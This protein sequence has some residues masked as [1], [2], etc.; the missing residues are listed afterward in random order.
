MDRQ[1]KRAH[2]ARRTP[3]PRRL[4]PEQIEAASVSRRTFLK[5]SGA[6]AAV[7]SVAVVTG[8]C[9]S[10]T[11]DD[12]PFQS[13]ITEPRPGAISDPTPPPPEIVPGGMLRFFSPDE[14]KLVDALASRIMPGSADDPGAHEAGVIWYIDGALAQ[15]VFNQPIYHEPPF[16]Q[17]YD[18]PT[19]PD[20]GDFNTVYVSKDELKRY[21]YQSALTPREMYRVGLA[22]LNSYAQKKFNGKFADISDD[23]K[24]SII[25]EMAGTEGNGAKKKPESASSGKAPIDEVFQAPSA[26]DFFKLVRD[27][28]IY[29][30]FADPAYGGN[31][32]MAG[33]KMIGYPG[34]QRAYTPR[35]MAT[36]GIGLQR[37]PQTL[38][39]LEVFH[40]GVDVGSG[41]ILPVS[42]SDVNRHH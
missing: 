2:D 30:M 1:E 15:G 19:P 28:V 20:N 4:D 41:V 31:R 14:A 32:D 36:E 12:D 23:Q 24:D 26:K 10:G 13:G 18:G 16:A 5:G 37:A 6:L 9:G 39:Q 42:G 29:G 3:R 38:A 21:G 17:S 40:P 35:D 22:S 8:S 25:D 34:A 27:D 7:A 11:G 33:W